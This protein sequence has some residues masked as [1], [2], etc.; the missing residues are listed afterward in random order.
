MSRI[1]KQNI[2]VPAGVSVVLNGESIIV[3]GP[4]GEL[5]RKLNPL[6]KLKAENNVITADVEN[7]DDKF[8]RS[9]WGTW[10]AHVKNMVAGVTE[11][12]KKEMEINGV[13]YKVALQDADL[14]LEVGY[15][16]PVIFKVPKG[17]KAEVEKN[18]IRLSGIDK[19]LLGNTAAGLRQVRC[20]EP[21]K[22]KGIKYA[23]EVIR[24]KAGKTAAKGAT[25]S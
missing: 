15:S 25:A 19:E 24:R 6:V 14:R 4:K 12:F 11:G 16:H 18:I 9:M 2:I 3:K 13:G 10:A 5:T 7:K 17:I 21:Y 1:G 20:P 8:F 22:G 23:D